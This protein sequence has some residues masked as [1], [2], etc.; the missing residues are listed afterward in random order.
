[1][2]YCSQDSRSTNQV[3]EAMQTYFRVVSCLPMIVL[4]EDKLEKE[5]GSKN[6]IQIAGKG[7]EN[8]SKIKCD[9]E[10]DF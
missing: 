1:M 6:S 9:V 2:M 8:K 10:A 4:S 5:R 7:A 3:L